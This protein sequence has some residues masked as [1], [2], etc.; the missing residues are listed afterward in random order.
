VNAEPPDAFLDVLGGGSFCHVGVQ[1]KAGPHVTPTVFVLSGG[2]IWITTSRMSVKARRWRRDP[3][4]SGL[5]RAD[6]AAVSFVGRAQ[7]YDVLDAD[8]WELALRRSP[9]LVV[10]ST[11]F[12]RKNA[13]F[14]AGYAV[15]ARHVP[16]AWAP[17]GRVFVEIEIERAALLE[18]G[19]IVET[20]GRWSPSLVSRER[21]RA[22]RKSTAVLTN[23]PSGI[24]KALGRK[25][26]GVLA[27]NGRRGTVTLPVAWS[28]EGR[29]LQTAL[30]SASLALAA[31]DERLARAALSIDRPSLWRAG[32]MMG[33][34]AQGTAELFV[35][36]RLRSGRASAE[37]CV[38]STG[39]DA[40]GSALV[41]LLPEQIV[42]WQG[43]TSGTV[44]PG[45]RG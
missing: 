4:A 27:V 15:D 38:A 17:P 30:P 3:R 24:R 10:A 7:T 31:C 2:R 41:R 44:R 42:W 21:F 6:E 45:G 9:A 8:T 20:W 29:W 35:V 12:A 32:R 34:M 14:F 23:V 37:G 13:R 40:A 25:G 22:T 11:R 36:D 5:V 26:H 1:T 28:A 19:I 16:L 33:A 39:A 43:W 18:G